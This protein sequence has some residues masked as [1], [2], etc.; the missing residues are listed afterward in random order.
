MM[1]VTVPPSSL[2][3][4]NRS[5]NGKMIQFDA[6]DRPAASRRRTLRSASP[7]PK[8]RARRHAIRT[9]PIRIAIGSAFDGVTKN[10][11]TLDAT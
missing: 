4:G 11:R 2:K 5:S 3:E 9:R 10:Q 8:R 1:P 7:Y 6:G